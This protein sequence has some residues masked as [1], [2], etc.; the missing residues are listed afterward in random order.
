MNDKEQFG[1]VLKEAKE[2]LG[3]NHNEF[4]NLIGHSRDSYLAWYRG[5][6]G[7]EDAKKEKILEAI[8]KA[9]SNIE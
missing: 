2:K 9:L 7:C 8:D 1:K 4:A 6:N 5:I 3:M